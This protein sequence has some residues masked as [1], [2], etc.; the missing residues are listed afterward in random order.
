MSILLS[1]DKKIITNI[2]ILNIIQSVHIF[3]DSEM[4]ET[5]LITDKR[6]DPRP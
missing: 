3:L 6:L 2:N 5:A 1:I 4:T